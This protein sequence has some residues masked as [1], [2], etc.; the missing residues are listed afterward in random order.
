M[1]DK[2]REA[3]E[4]KRRAEEEEEDEALAGE[5]GDQDEADDEGEAD[6]PAE[7]AE[8]AEKLEKAKEAPAPKVIQA[9]P[10]RPAP[11]RSARLAQRR[12]PPKGSLA[13]SLMLFVI[14]VGG[15]IVVF[16]FISR[17]EPNAGGPA[18]APKWTIGQTVDLELTVVPS[19]SKDLACSSAED[20]GGKKCQFETPGKPYAPA[21]TDDKK[22]LKP[23]TTTDRIQ[24]IGAGLWAEP[25]LDPAKLPNTRFSVK[26]KYKIEAKMKSPGIRWAGEGPWFPQ[27]TDWNAGT[28]SGC[29]I[30]PP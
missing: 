14:I 13:K 16:A 9:K 23:Y 18:P 30:A 29:T 15:L 7:K 4:A 1:A 24:I 25:A 17:E 3:D 28:F 19:D 6:E 20:V 2:D 26:C 12:Q 21:Q 11:Q 22:I 5:G 10:E 27:T 8:A